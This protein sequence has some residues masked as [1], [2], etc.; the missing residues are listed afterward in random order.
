[1]N[2]FN[3]DVQKWN[4]HLRHGCGDLDRTFAVASRVVVYE[5]SSRQAVNWVIEQEP[6]DEPV[7]CRRAVVVPPAACSDVEVAIRRSVRA[8]ERQRVER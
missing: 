8:A 6:T 3:R 7:G 5:V 1:M 4:H 2:L